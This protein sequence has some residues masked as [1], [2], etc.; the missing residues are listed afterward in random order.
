MFDKVL[1]ANRGEIAVRVIRACRDLGIRT[2]AVF[3]DA[4]RGALHVRMADE[5]YPIGPAP[6]SDS[7]LHIER[8]LEAARA[9]RVDAVH[10]GY[11]FLSENAAFAR[12][13]ADTGLVFVG[14]S[15]ASIAL[16]GSKVD[17]RN[18]V[19]NAGVRV[20]PGS[21]EAITSDSG[22]REA[23]ADIGYPLMVKASAGGG[24][25]GMRQVDRPEAL[26]AALREARAEARAA[27][28]DDAVYIERVIRQPRHIEVQIVSDRFGRA[29]HI[30]ER[31]CTIQRR[32]QKLIEEA[33]SPIVD[34]GLREAMGEAALRV[35]RS[36]GYDNVGTV[37]FLLDGETRQFYFL[38]MNTR[39]Q[40]EH[41]VTEA[42]TGID[43]VTLQLR[44][45][46]GEQLAIRQEDVRLDGAAIECRIYA[47]DPENEFFPSPGRI[48]RLETPSG[49]GI[50]E[51]SGIYAGWTVPLEYDP[52]LAKLIAWGPT[53]PEA[54]ARMRRALAEYRID[55]IRSNIGFFGE[56]LGHPAIRD[57]RFD[58]GFVDD[59]LRD[60]VGQVPSEESR[61]LAVLAAAV[62]MRD[63]DP[64]GRAD[65][66]S[67]PPG[68]WKLEGRRRGLRSA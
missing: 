67:P 23:A 9:A 16:M 40:V 46:A 7:Y 44:I 4:D 11:G 10:P 34:P 45:A 39:I 31:E 25:K 2:A 60:R 14:P 17:S 24:G 42:V 51:D 66:V 27:F 15:A 35:A 52:L 28:G 13:V 3:S 5:A 50:R 26:E 62:F 57:G 32:H 68:P 6:S 58:T 56:V 20:V 61:A 54:I 37:E 59:W 65:G 1:I 18:A 53:R 8:I 30:G 21:F 29:V 49:P 64:A 55:G 36:A 22:A 41:P 48:L 47:E 33:P 38:E 19:S 12:A 63:P 43:L